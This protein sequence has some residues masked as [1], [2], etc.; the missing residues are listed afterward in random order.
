MSL[1]RQ[2]KLLKLPLNRP[3]ERGERELS[4]RVIKSPLLG[5]AEKALV[6]LERYLKKVNYRGWDPHDALLSPF[7]FSL[8]KKSRV[9]AILFTQLIKKSPVNLRPLL[10]IPWQFNPKANA[11][12]LRGYLYKYQLW[13]KQEDWKQ[14]EALASWLLE[15][16]SVS[17]PGAGWGYPFPWAN[18]SFFAPA[19]LPN[20]VVT[21][22]VGH[23][24]L[25]FYKQSK[26]EAFLQKAV[27]A[28]EFVSQGLNRTGHDKSFCFS[29]TSL[30]H[31]CI[32]NANMLG[33]SLLSRV[34][35]LLADDRY[36]SLSRQAMSFSLERQNKNGSW[37]YGE[38]KRLR[39][40]DSFHS[41]YS[42]AALA[43][44][45]DS[46]P[47]KEAIAAYEAGVS[48]YLKTFFLPQ[49]WVKFTDRSLYP[50]D[51][52]A[53]AQAIISLS[54]LPQLS[55]EVDLLMK[56]TE[57]FLDIFWLKK[58]YF[59]YQRQ[60]WGIISIPYLRW[61]QAWAFL[62]LGS[63]L[64]YNNCLTERDQC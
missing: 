50:L 22:F 60:K 41:G 1:Y 15:N 3:N 45:L 47:L 43:I 44:Y 42:L 36:L 7:L 48:Y 21:S 24:L 49:G 30:D 17:G 29:Y 6:Q 56:V 19:G 5:R 23:S 10:R 16:A 52:H 39:W 14:A 11:L 27:D 32:H 46:N 37:F 33:A 25:D 20:I 64:L 4:R 35:A 34:G 8:A 28:S 51:A 63:F 31:A 12:F 26:N 40:V 53:F 57:S 59:A 13:K 54:S 62:S 58:G 61:V 2:A 38:G 18:R 55:K 9:L